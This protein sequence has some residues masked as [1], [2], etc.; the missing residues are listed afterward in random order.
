ML[1]QYFDLILNKTHIYFISE[2]TSRIYLITYV[3]LSYTCWYIIA[4]EV[5]VK[6]RYDILWDE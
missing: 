6:E 3:V 2:Y 1:L 5:D 4:S